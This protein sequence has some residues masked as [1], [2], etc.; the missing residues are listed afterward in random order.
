VTEY[1]TQACEEIATFPD[2]DR[3]G[4]QSYWARQFPFEK[5]ADLDH[6]IEGLRKAGLPA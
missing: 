4:W 3:E 1:L 2:Q 6:L 5:R